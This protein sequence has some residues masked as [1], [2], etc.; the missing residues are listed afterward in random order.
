MYN[1][2][3]TLKSIYSIFVKTIILHSKNVLCSI[4]N[5]YIEY[6]RYIY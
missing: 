4:D 6:G 3:T 1:D 5:L 2:K